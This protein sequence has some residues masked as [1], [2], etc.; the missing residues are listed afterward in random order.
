M[1]TNRPITCRESCH[2]CGQAYSY[3]LKCYIL[4]PLALFKHTIWKTNAKIRVECVCTVLSNSNVA[5]FVFRV[6]TYFEP[7]IL[8]F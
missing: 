3:T 1:A 5:T 7:C 2:F 6:S 8:Q 4:I